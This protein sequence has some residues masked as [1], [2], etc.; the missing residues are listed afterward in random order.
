MRGVQALFSLLSAF[1]HRVWT[2]LLCYQRFF[3]PSTE[4]VINE[5]P[6][7]LSFLKYTFPRLSPHAFH[8]SLT[9]PFR[10]CVCICVV[11]TADPSS[12]YVTNIV[13]FLSISSPLSQGYHYLSVISASLLPR[14]ICTWVIKRN[15]F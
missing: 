1:L 2:L 12:H 9:N 3:Q 10:F 5:S 6:L 7:S 14:C 11:L 8:Y 15:N 4:E 13:S